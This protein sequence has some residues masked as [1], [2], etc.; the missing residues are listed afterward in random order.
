MYKMINR[1]LPLLVLA[2][3][4]AF[5]MA[6]SDLPKGLTYVYET[7]PLKDFELPT[8]TGDT[9][10]L[11]DHK[12]KVVLVNFWATWCPP[13]REEMPGIHNVW[14]QLKDKGFEVLA[15]NLGE[16]AEDVDRFIFEY[17][18]ED[19][20]YFL[21]DSESEAMKLLEVKGLPTT[22]IVD[23]EGNKYYE[24]LGPRQFDSEEIVSLITELLEN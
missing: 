2:A 15:V 23:K 14:M 1:T 18:L 24:A 10:K 4:F 12:G 11:S 3:L 7:P 5:S 20:F 13:C 6:K 19:S 17:G 9:M 8:M 16:D 22:F 21:L